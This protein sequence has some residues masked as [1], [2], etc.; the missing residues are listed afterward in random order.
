MNLAPPGAK[1]DARVPLKDA[2]DAVWHRWGGGWNKGKE[3]PPEVRAKIS[4]ALKGKPQPW[5]HD[6]MRGRHHSEE[7]QEKIAAS[8]RKGP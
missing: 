5:R 1:G 4:R 8:K 3:T 2:L 6:G 7:T